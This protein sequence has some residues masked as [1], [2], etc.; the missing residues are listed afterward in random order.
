MPMET[1]NNIEK[2]LRDKFYTDPAW[3]H[4]E[5]KILAY[6]EPLLDLSTVDMTD[7]AEN[8]KVEVKGRLIAHKQMMKFLDESGIIR[9]KTPTKTT[10]K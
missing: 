5:D 3:K 4:I 10:F 1:P 8:V 6:I 2:E 9:K 7:K